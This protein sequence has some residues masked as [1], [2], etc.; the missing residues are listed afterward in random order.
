MIVRRIAW[1]QLMVN[2]LSL[3]A[4]AQHSQLPARSE[5][6]RPATLLWK[7]GIN[8]PAGASEMLEA[9]T[10]AM[11]G[12]QKSWRATHYSHDPTTSPVNDFDLYDVDATT[13]EPIRNV[14]QTPDFRLEISFTRAGASLRHITESAAKEEYVPLAVRV[15]PEGPGERIFVASLPL[16]DSFELKYHILDRWSGDGP[17]RLKSTTLSVDGRKRLSTSQGTRE[18][19]QVRIRPDDGSFEI[20]EY[21]RTKPPFYPYR[22]EYSRGSLH[23]VSEVVMMIFSSE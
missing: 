17:S 18:A 9:I 15:M 22:V 10:P 16:R 2:C 11:V 21:V 14:M 3:A 13:L 5:A 20:L 8:N 1:F 7:V 6:I 23:S 12:G 4:C 19:F